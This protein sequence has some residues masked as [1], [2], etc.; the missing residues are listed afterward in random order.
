VNVK[1]KSLENQIELWTLLGPFIMV[2]TLII[3]LI[4]PDQHQLAIPIVGLFGLPICWK[5]KLPGLAIS[6]GMLA[7]VTVYQVI[8]NSSGIIIWDFTLAF[9]V[10]L[11]FCIT[12]LSYKETS[13]VLSR[14]QDESFSRLQNLKQAND[15]LKSIEQ[16]KIETENTFQSKVGLLH[17]QLVDKS[18]AL[19]SYEQITAIA[20]EEILHVNKEK[21]NLMQELLQLR[22]KSELIRQDYE[23]ISALRHEEKIALAEKQEE[24]TVHKQQIEALNEEKKLL[25]NSLAN[26]EKEIQSL[27]SL[28]Q[29]KNLQFQEYTDSIQNLHKQS[30]MYEQELLQ[31]REKSEALMSACDNKEK[32]LTVQLQAYETKCVQAEERILQLEQS[33]QEI[34]DNEKQQQQQPLPATD[35]RDIRRAEGLYWQLREQFEEKNNTLEGI[36]RE[37]FFTQEELARCRKELETEQAYSAGNEIESKLDSHILKNEKE[38]ALLEKRYREEVDALQGLVEHFIAQKPDTVQN[39]QTAETKPETKKKSSKQKKT[40]DWANTILSRW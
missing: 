6:L 12:A 22:H 27:R 20:R 10:A 25:E 9:A 4:K 5:W 30:S 13:T 3:I 32:A 14:L 38:L 26:V 18:S 15:K 19:Q 17:A 2:V 1:E 36:R 16:T 21:E 23:E 33:L 40:T 35:D 28:D 8:Q 29:Q 7:A 37:L 34:K 31:Y 11:T 39:V 24:V